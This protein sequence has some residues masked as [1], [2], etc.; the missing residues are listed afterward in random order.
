MV[1][2]LPW[3]TYIICGKANNSHGNTSTTAVL[4]FGNITIPFLPLVSYS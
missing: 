1:E 3:K 2:I 4:M